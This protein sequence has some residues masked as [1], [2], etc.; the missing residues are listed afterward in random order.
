MCRLWRA[1]H[2]PRRENRMTEIAKRVLFGCCVVVV[3]SGFAASP[4][5]G[6]RVWHQGDMWLKWSHDARESYVL[7]Y[8]EGSQGGEQSSKPQVLEADTA[9]IVKSITDFYTRHPEDR[10]IYIREVIEQLREGLTIE[11][12]HDYPFFRHQP[13]K[14]KP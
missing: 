10:D 13:P 1:G 8:F 4:L 11:Q 7:G 12:I 6:Q 14:A 5:L 2:P 9:P 3:A